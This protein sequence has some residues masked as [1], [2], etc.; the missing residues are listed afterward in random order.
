[1]C[2]ETDDKNPGGEGEANEGIAI[3]EGLPEP[4][5]PPVVPKNAL[6]PPV[7]GSMI[8]DDKLNVA[9]MQA[10]VDLPLSDIDENSKAI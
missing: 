2:K 7:H 10:F 9:E 8:I 5:R 3:P 6:V 1:M 4:G